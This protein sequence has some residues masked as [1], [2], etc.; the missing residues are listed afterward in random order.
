MSSKNKKHFSKRMKIQVC[1]LLQ[2]LAETAIK[3]RCF[4][5]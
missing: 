4:E 3:R 2:G 1:E 5:K